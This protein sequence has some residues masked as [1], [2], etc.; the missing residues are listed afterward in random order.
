VNNPN[1]ELTYDF[2]ATR[3]T[4]ND[5]GSAGFA[6]PLTLTI[7]YAGVSSDMEAP[8][9]IWIKPDGNAEALPTVVNA[10]AQTMS[11]QV[12]HFSIYGGADTLL[13]WVVCTLFC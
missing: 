8:V 12:T 6:V 11:A 10:A 5:V 1:G 3:E 4:P 9:I 7:S 13:G 2:T